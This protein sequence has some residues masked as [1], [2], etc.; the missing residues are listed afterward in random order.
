[1]ATHSSVLAWRIPGKMV[2]CHLWGHTESDTTEATYHQQYSIIHVYHN[3]FIHL[4][5]DGHLGCFYLLAIV[6]WCC[7]EGVSTSFLLWGGMYLEMK[8]LSHMV[9]LYLIFGA[10]AKLFYKVA[11]P[12]YNPI[13]M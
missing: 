1:M 11:E 4:S 10:T 5:V 12:F 9:I 8:L 2:G 7:Y 13:A 3:L 6:K